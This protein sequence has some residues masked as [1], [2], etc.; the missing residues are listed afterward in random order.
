MS[1]ILPDRAL[2]AITSITYLT[3]LSNMLVSSSSHHKGVIHIGQFCFTFIRNRFIKAVDINNS[4]GQLLINLMIDL[5]HLVL[6]LSSIYITL[7]LLQTLMSAARVGPI[8]CTTATPTP[9]ARTMKVDGTA[10]A[11]LAI[12]ETESRAQVR[13]PFH[14]MKSLL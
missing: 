12:L 9:T 6:R 1:L 14:C 2:F 8:S 13:D 11:K 5:V 7:V 4:S 10:P 3:P